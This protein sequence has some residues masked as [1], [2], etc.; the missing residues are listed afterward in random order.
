[1]VLD[2]SGGGRKFQTYI[3]SCDTLN[4]WFIKIIYAYNNYVDI[5]KVN[6]YD[7]ITISTTKSTNGY[8]TVQQW[9]MIMKLLSKLTELIT[10][11]H[12]KNWTES[13]DR[14]NH[15]DLYIQSRFL[16]NWTLS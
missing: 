11:L 15:G 4:I 9:T 3:C 13:K 10:L 12:I 5:D 8:E 7:Y 6:F 14:S 2:A 16:E 1:M